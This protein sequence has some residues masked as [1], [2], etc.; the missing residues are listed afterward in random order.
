[1]VAEESLPVLRVSG[2]G[3]LGKLSRDVP[4]PMAFRLRGVYSLPFHGKVLDAAHARRVRQAGRIYPEA[5]DEFKRACCRPI[6]LLCALLPGCTCPVKPGEAVKPRPRPSWTRVR[7]TYRNLAGYHFERVLLLQEERE[8]GKLADIVE[9]DARD[10]SSKNA[11]SVP[12]SERLL[13]VNLRPRVRLA[14]KNEAE[15]DA[16]GVRRPDLLVIHVFEE[17][18]HERGR[19]SEM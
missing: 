17:R 19:G 18:V 7:E 15:R 9:L 8:D 14:T 3:A 6:V 5:H 10:R 12:D 16:A 11:T 13:R 1:V 4:M 2:M